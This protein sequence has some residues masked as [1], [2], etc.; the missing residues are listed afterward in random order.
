[1]S[2]IRNKQKDIPGFL[3]LK[4]KTVEKKLMSTRTQVQ[5]LNENSVPSIFLKREVKTRNNWKPLFEAN[6]S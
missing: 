5:I 2:I 1:M 6:F 3:N 4:L